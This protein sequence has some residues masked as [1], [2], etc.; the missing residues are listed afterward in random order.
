MRLQSI[1]S[2]FIL[3]YFS[4][5]FFAC[6]ISPAES[7]TSFQGDRKND[8]PQLDPPDSLVIPP[9]PVLTPEEALATFQ[10]DP[11]FSIELVAS[12]PDIQAPIAMKF[13]EKGR[14]WI[15]EMFGYMSDLRGTDEES[16]TGR[17]VI[18]TDSDQD[19]KADMSHVFLDSLVLPRAIALIYG[20]LLYAEP[21]NLWFREILEGDMP[22]EKILVD[23]VYAVGGNVEHQPNALLVGMDNWIYSAKSRYRY[24]RIKGEWIKQ[25]TE[26]RGQWGMSQDDKGRLFYNTNSNQLRGDLVWPNTMMKNV[27][28]VPTF[29]TNREIA[30]DQRVYPERITTGVNRGYREATLDKQYRLRRFTAACGP[31]IYRGTH[32]PHTY[33]GNAFVAEPAGNLIKRNILYEKNARI[34]SQQAYLGREFLTSSDERFRPVNLYNGPDGC[35]YVLDMYR[36]IV[37]HKTYMTGYLYRQVVAR[38][39]DKP[40]N[41]GRIY[42]IIHDKG[43]KIDLPDLSKTTSFE[44]LKLLSHP[45]AWHREKA[46]QLLVERGPQEE[47]FADI[48][49]QIKQADR[50]IAA[51]HALWIL[52]GWNRLS[53]NHIRIALQSDASEIVALGIRMGAFFGRTPQASEILSMFASLQDRTETDT[54]LQLALS[55]GAFRQPLAFEMLEKLAVRYDDDPL[56]REAVVSSLGGEEEEMY[57]TLVQRKEKADQVISML[58]DLISPTDEAILLGSLALDETE[59]QQFDEGRKL[60]EHHCSGCHQMNGKGLEPIAPPLVRSEYVLGS[61]KTLIM[62]A[63]HGLTGPVTVNGIT[64]EPP[65]VQAQM[66]G[67]KDNSA[68]TDENIAAVLSYVRNAWGNRSS[69]IDKERVS[70]LRTETKKRTELLTEKELHAMGLLEPNQKKNITAL[71]K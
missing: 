23:S 36:G 13:D 22:G 2:L 15:V 52:E 9:A 4:I 58:S 33:Y 3:S 71:S 44:L 43:Q 31:L 41:L 42:R 48:E 12:E 24:R 34:F 70:I 49:A 50:P 28:F 32:F 46:Q 8:E 64:Y 17:I 27:N 55:L 40:V 56:M 62:V 69:F 30:H 54:Q 38:G 45:N 5:H 66:P 16:K 18:L 20:G 10:L 61:E 63:L 51:M 60:Y 14:M 53:P 21:P 11:G 1:F 7:P 37:Q 19:G 26:F 67:L 68:F 57:E 35:M 65:R 59:Q 25:E 39:L 29:G 6:E 47:L